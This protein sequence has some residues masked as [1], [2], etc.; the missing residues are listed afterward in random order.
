MNCIWCEYTEH[1][2]EDINEKTNDNN[3]SNDCM[4]MICDCY[5]II[6]LNIT[7]C[8][9]CQYTATSK[10]NPSRFSSEKA[11]VNSN[12]NVSKKPECMFIFNELI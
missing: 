6:Y 3:S 12:A 8:I 10:S 11:S 5:G 4:S 2:N 1:R 7:N 9:C